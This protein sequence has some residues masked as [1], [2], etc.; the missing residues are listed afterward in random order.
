VIH[1]FLNTSTENNYVR[2]EPEKNSFNLGFIKSGP[3][4]IFAKTFAK[5]YHLRANPDKSN[6]VTMPCCTS[7]RV[8]DVVLLSRTGTF[9]RDAATHVDHWVYVG[10]IC[11]GNKFDLILASQLSGKQYCF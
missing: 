5:C 2:L 8:L 10:T 1:I 6:S 9:L 3:L 11:D 7:R 4:R